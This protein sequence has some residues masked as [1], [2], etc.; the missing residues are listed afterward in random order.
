MKMQFGVPGL[1][2]IDCTCLLHSSLFHS[3]SFSSV[4]GANSNIHNIR[5][6]VVTDALCRLNRCQRGGQSQSCHSTPSLAMWFCPAE[7]R[8]GC[9]LRCPQM[10]SWKGCAW[11]IWL[12]LPGTLFSPL[13]MRPA[14]AQTTLDQG[15]PMRVTGRHQITCQ[16]RHTFCICSR[17]PGHHLGSVAWMI[18]YC[19][20]REAFPAG[21]TERNCVE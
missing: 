16:V 11:P 20:F 2:A 9:R 1:H 17:V 4:H 13:Q 3:H 7:R 18:A 10:Q 6:G 15:L 14:P 12:L 5:K 19:S 21:L 8:L